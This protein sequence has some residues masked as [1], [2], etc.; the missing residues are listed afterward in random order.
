MYLITD[1]STPIK[2]IQKYLRITPNGIFDERTKRAVMQHQV[3]NGLTV[4][5]V[6]DYETFLSLKNNNQY[7]ENHL[8][9]KSV[10][11]NASFPYFFGNSGN[12]IAQI[13]SILREVIGN[14]TVETRLPGGN[15]YNTYTEEATLRLREIFGLR[16]SKQIDEEFFTR[17]YKEYRNMKTI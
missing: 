7:R 13:N 14:Y 11:Y 2:V 16:A 15:Y 5:G 10:I 17:L 3:K 8:L 1:K 6:V 12:D 4:T 9:S